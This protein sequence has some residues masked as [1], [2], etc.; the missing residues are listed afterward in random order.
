MARRSG[1]SLDLEIYTACDRNYLR[2]TIVLCRSIAL[3]SPVSEITILSVGLSEDERRQIAERAWLRVRF[4][5]VEPP[6]GPTPLYFTPA[7]YARLLAPEVI[8]AD[9]LLYLDCDM[10]VTD[11]LSE[12]L[13]TDLGDHPVAGVPSPYIETIALSGVSSGDIARCEVDPHARWMSACVVLIDTE[14]WLADR[15]GRRAIAYAQSAETIDLADEQALNMMIGG[16]FQ[17]LPLRWNQIRMLRELKPAVYLRLL[18]IYTRSEVS[19]A[20]LDPGIVH[21]L[22][23]DKPWTT[24]PIDRWSARWHHLWN[25]EICETP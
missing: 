6:D 19:R 7:I 10:I 9:R 11:D 20:A 23:P 14:R 2:G 3:T 8:E 13:G 15:I 24:G 5:E 18:E 17:P 1:I 25:L 22:G 12:I 21:F 4:V 16:S